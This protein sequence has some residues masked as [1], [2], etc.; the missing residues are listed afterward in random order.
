[1]KYFINFKW[2]LCIT[3]RVA[4]FFLHLNASPIGH[5]RRSKVKKTVPAQVPLE[6]MLKKIR[7]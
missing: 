5:A 1:M 6:F 2:Q 3:R 4:L 7:K